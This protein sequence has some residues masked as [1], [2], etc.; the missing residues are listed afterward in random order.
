MLPRAILFDLDDTI[1]SAFGQSE[2]QW[3]QIIG[4]YA[5]RLAPLV[6]A[7]VVRAVMA[8]SAWLWADA[9]RHKHW[10]MQI[11]NARRHIVANAFAE[12]AAAGHAEHPRELGEEIADRF[13]ALHEAEM[14][15]FPGAHETLDRLKEMGVRLALITNGAGA[16]QRAKVTR[17]ALEHRFDHIQ[18]E[19]EHGFG[20]P[21]EQAYRHAMAALGVGPEETWMVGD[22]LEWEVAA[23][24]RLGIYAIWHD[25][26]GVG[27]PGGSPVR[28]DR[29][30]RSLPELLP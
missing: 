13:Q 15:M 9:S 2:R 24:Q 1:I 12:L 10:R 29:I 16:P 26:Y 14:R 30:I 3:Q 6:P 23:P 4:E 8:Q 7:D 21:E 27:L 25:G 19:G 18:I 5:E 11:G 22:N 17:F 20:K 28:P